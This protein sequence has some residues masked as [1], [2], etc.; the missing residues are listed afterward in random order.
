MRVYVCVRAYVCVCVCACMHCLPLVV[1]NLPCSCGDNE[2]EAA[3]AW[4]ASLGHHPWDD[5]R[6]WLTRDDEQA[7]V[8]QRH[9]GRCIDL[10]RRC[11]VRCLLYT[12]PINHTPVSRVGPAEDTSDVYQVRPW[13]SRCDKDCM[14]SYG[15]FKVQKAHIERCGMW[16]RCAWLAGNTS[17]LSQGHPWESRCVVRIACLVTIAKAFVLRPLRDPNLCLER[18]HM[19][20]KRQVGVLCQPHLT[21]PDGVER[22]V[23]DPVGLGTVNREAHSRWYHLRDRVGGGAPSRAVLVPLCN[24][25]PNLSQTLDESPDAERKRFGGTKSDIKQPHL[26]GIVGAFLVHHWGV[27]AVVLNTQAISQ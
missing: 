14:C 24:R 23:I 12:E 9:V 10:P 4:H 22:P 6:Q 26:H 18:L 16:R 8:C 11:V 7:R 15:S 21:R 1:Q 5:R 20:K 25:S 27:V 19:P 3:A 2:R 17:S 13:K